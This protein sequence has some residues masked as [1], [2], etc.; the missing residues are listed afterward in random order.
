M[1]RGPAAHESDDGLSARSVSIP[2]ALIG[3]LALD[4]SLC[5]Y[6]EHGQWPGLEPLV[7]AGW[8]CWSPTV[9]HKEKARVLILVPLPC[10]LPLGT[11]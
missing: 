3:H 1:S 7:P 9:E 5:K 10:F 2:M 8:L 6:A 4:G 11:G